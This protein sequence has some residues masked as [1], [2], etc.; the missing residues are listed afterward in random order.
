MIKI[1]DTFNNKV[2][3][4]GELEDLQ[5][6]YFDEMEKIEEKYDVY[7]LIDHKA[8]RETMNF[9]KKAVTCIEIEDIEELCDAINEYHK[10]LGIETSM[11]L[12]K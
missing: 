12:E 4:E 6:K 8:E 1:I 7:E 10:K 9:L 2:Y 3:F 11:K 5:E